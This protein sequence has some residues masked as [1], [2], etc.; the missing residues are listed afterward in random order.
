MYSLLEKTTVK[1]L[2]Y[3]FVVLHINPKYHYLASDST[4]DI[5]TK[6]EYTEDHPLFIKFTALLTHKFFYRKQNLTL[7]STAK[8]LKTNRSTLS[9][10]VNQVTGKRFDE[11]ISE[12]RINEAKKLLCA[13]NAAKYK[14]E[15]IGSEV[16]FAHVSTFYSTFKKYTGVSPA[17]FREDYKCPK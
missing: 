2:P 5:L 15:A 8:K 7:D 4:N 3:P 9:K 14:V 13:P 10:I 12:Y 6:V 11:I 17:K 16:G 1:K